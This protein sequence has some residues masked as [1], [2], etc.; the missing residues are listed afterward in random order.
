MAKALTFWGV[1]GFLLAVIGGVVAIANWPDTTTKSEVTVSGLQ[2]SV[3]SVTETGS[4]AAANVGLIMLG[5]G[6]TVLWVVLIAFGVYCGLRMK[7]EREEGREARRQVDAT[8]ADK[9]RQAR[10]DRQRRMVAKPA[11]EERPTT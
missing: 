8:I 10:E 5:V 6:S 2:P 4:E 7:E 11:D 3:T 9:N 1:I